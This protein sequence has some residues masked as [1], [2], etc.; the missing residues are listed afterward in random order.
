MLQGRTVLDE[1]T[2]ITSCSS[3]CVANGSDGFNGHLADSSKP[4]GSASASSRDVDD[5]ADDLGGIQLSNLIGS[6]ASHIRATPRPLIKSDDLIA[7][8]DQVDNNIAK[9]IKLVEDA[10]R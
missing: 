10:L 2:T 1:G 6:Y 3:I 8:I 4:E 9:C 7:G 5:L